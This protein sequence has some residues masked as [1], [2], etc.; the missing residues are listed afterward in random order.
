[1]N[2]FVVLVILIY[3]DAFQL[4]CTHF[5]FYYNRYDV[6]RKY[7]LQVHR[8]YILA[9]IT[10]SNSAPFIFMHAYFVI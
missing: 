6:M 8:I 10:I 7:S 3:P 5:P 4:I 1:M 9:T 2:C